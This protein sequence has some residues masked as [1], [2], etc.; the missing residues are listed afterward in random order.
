MAIF[1]FAN[2]MARRG[3]H[4]ELWHLDLLGERIHDLSEIGY[5]DFDPGVQH[6]IPARFDVSDL[7]EADFV[8]CFDGRIPTHGGLPLMFI[9][10][11]RILPPEIETAIY[12][13]PCPRICIS[14]WLR[15]VALA[16][17]ASARQAVHI[18]YGIDHQK[19]RF[20]TDPDRRPVRV[21]MLYNPHPTKRADLGFAAI[22]QTQE[23]IPEVEG[24]FF[25]TTSPNVTLPERSTFVH[26]PSQPKLVNDIYNGSRV[27]VSASQVEGFGLAAAE[28]MSCGCALATTDNGGASDY[29]VHGETALV[30]PPGDADAL[31]ANIVTL[32]RDDERRS[33]VVRGG[34]SLT[35]DLQWDRSA[36][37]LESLL[38]DY[39][40][41]PDA[42]RRPVGPADAQYAQALRGLDLLFRTS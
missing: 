27:F 14:T 10:A 8:F 30:S 31:A 18:P 23:M 38:A 26:N 36:E 12:R 2:G 21:A 41:D 20:V 3:H 40:T 16:H 13:A 17:G 4:V 19:Y 11:F 28:A 39:R 32:L 24:V 6:H 7:P 1:E 9:Q 25:G 33:Q 34:M 37:L 35:A 29:A 15:R 22:R 5:F 42:Y